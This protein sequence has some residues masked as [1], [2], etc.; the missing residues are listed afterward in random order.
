MSAMAARDPGGF[1]WI[2]S[3]R[4]KGM[5]IALGRIAVRRPAGQSAGRSGAVVDLRNAAAPVG[6]GSDKGWP[7]LPALPEGIEMFEALVE[8]SG[9]DREL[10]ESDRRRQG[11]IRER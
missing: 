3:I 11:D 5:M 1:P 2:R 6:I 8:R 7:G 10:R 9:V 4:A